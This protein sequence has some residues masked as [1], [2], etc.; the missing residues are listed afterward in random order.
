MAETLIRSPRPA[1][2]SY[3]LTPTGKAALERV[4]RAAEGHLAVL[5]AP[6][7]AASRRRLQGGL[8]VLRR[9]FS[10]APSPASGR[11]LRAAR[12]PKQR[13]ST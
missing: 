4:G 1:A 10:D 7:D 5:L 13:T 8:G 3:R 6:L 9:V 12:A 11:V 2:H